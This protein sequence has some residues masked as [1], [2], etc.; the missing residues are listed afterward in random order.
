MFKFLG[1]LFDSNEKQIERLRKIV[2]NINSL[3]NKY[4]AMSFSDMR[5]EMDTYRAKV[6]ELVAKIPQSEKESIRKYTKTTLEKELEKYLIEI[7]PDVFAMIREVA[8]RK[9]DRR[10]FDVQLIAG[11]VLTEG[12]IAEVKTGEGKT[13]IAWLPLALFGLTKRGAHLVTVNDYLARSHGEYAGHI[14]S[15]LGFSVG[16][17]EPNKSYVFVTQD[18]LEKLDVEKFEEA[19]K[20]PIRNPGDTR[21]LNLKQATKKEAYDCDIVYATNNE[22][23]FDHLKDNMVDKLS[24]LVQKELY[25]CIVDEVDSIL[26]DEARTP[27][28]I[29]MPASRSNDLY[30][31]FANLVE[32]LDLKLVVVDEKHKSVNLTDEGA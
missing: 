17:T 24:E 9:F 2:K 8:K 31:K 3:E 15:E 10:H 14:F 25:F 27:L 21:G 23:G 19:V 6:A 4:E 18:E 22:I 26:I 13:Q 1:N 20:L 5:L 28:I 32:N 29:S 7:M 12:K 16:I 30:L 11:I